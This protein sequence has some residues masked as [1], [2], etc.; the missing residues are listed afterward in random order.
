MR[1]GIDFDDVVA[2]SMGV[3]IDLQNK[4]YGTSYKREDATSFNLENIWGGTKEEWQAKLDEFLSAKHHN[5][6]NPMAGV[7]PA[8][9]A[10]KKMGHEL[11]IVTGRSESY[12]VN[13]DP[14]IEKHFP[15]TFKGVHYANHLLDT[16]E[17]RTKASI[18]KENGIEVIIED[19]M[20]TATECAVAGIRALL[21][22]QPWNQGELQPGVERV[23]SWEE[24]VEKLS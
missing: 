20:R 22:D 2:D 5:S 8:M 18:C 13:T 24:I 17:R 11:Y 15:D 3:V 10:L 16:S 9:D 12:A 4:K 14:W 1:I 19:H 7:I 6:L 21:L 23:R